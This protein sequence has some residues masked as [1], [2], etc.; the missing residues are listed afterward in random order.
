MIYYM[1][2]LAGKKPLNRGGNNGNMCHL[3]INAEEFNP[4]VMF[5]YKQ[6]MV[7]E[8]PEH[9]HDFL[10]IQ[11]VVSGRCSYV[12]NGQELEAKKEDLVILNPGTL[13]RSLPSHGK[14]EATVFYLGFEN[15]NIKG[16][17]D[18]YIPIYNTV[19]PIR[20]Y[21]HEI[22][23][24]YHE[25]IATQEKKDV[26]W[27]LLTKVLS[28]QFLVLVLKELSPQRSG[29]I[30]DYFQLKMYDKNTIAQTI[31]QYFQ[32]NYMKK[33]S[34]EEI[35]RYTYLSTTYVT[36]IYKEITGDTP[37]NYLINLRMNKAQEIL[38]EGHFSVQEVAKQVGYEDPY[39]FS[40]LFKKRYGC[41]PSE[42]K[43]KSS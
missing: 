28:Q 39:Y 35:A 42:Y 41:S 18:N 10:T 19:I 43:K 6:K 34:V 24:C 20:K 22:Y 17:P 25:I 21:Q 11:Y 40:K 14:N 2:S 4:K 23:N 37:I 15:L 31:T 26:G 29:N 30:Q 16:Y 1:G 33:I 36:K 7:Y 8:V 13:H 27:D 32:E 12:I 5:H 9:T 38:R 3:K